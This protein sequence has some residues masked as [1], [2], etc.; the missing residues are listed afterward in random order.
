[1]P[2]TREVKT[3]DDLTPEEQS[4]T[5]E[6]LG[7]QPKKTK[8]WNEA[9]SKGARKADPRKRSASVHGARAKQT[10]EAEEVH[11]YADEPWVR[12]ATLPHIPAREGFVQ[13]WVRVSVRGDHDATNVSSKFREG[14]RPRK[15]DTLPKDFPV[16]KI[17]QGHYTGCIGVGGNI[18][19]EMPKERNNQ[20]N[21]FYRKRRERQTAAIN[22]ELAQASS[23]G[24]AGFGHIERAQKSMVVR[25]VAAADDE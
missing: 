17:E 16:P 13:R 4:A 9:N 15:A 14:W 3:Q 18:L 24:H 10:R 8:D 20:R 12:P 7:K 1:V 5:A 19:C 23:H 22:A 6:I 11:E 25:E 21:A 2:K